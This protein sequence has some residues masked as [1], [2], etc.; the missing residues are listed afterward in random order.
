MRVRSV[1]DIFGVRGHR[2]A[3]RA[4]PKP[5]LDDER[6]GWIRSWDYFRFRVACAPMRFLR[7]VVVSESVV[8]LLCLSR[9]VHVGEVYLFTVVCLF[10][11]PSLQALRAET[12]V[13]RFTARMHVR[14]SA[15]SLVCVGACGWR[16]VSGEICF[17][18][19]LWGLRSVRERKM[20]MRRKG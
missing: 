15:C 2:S 4:F 12:M 9:L 18:P 19:D 8:L 6:F 7:L 1:R 10:E 3:P 17:I 20:C 14:P 11:M 16:A 5:N 13:E